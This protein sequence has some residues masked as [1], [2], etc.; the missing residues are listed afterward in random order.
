MKLLWLTLRQATARW[1][2]PVQRGDLALQQF[3]IRFKGRVTV[4]LGG[5]SSGSLTQKFGHSL[6]GSSIGNLRRFGWAPD[7]HWVH[8]RML[9]KRGACLTMLGARAA[10]SLAATMTIRG[11][12]TG[13]VF[14]A[15]TAKFLTPRPSIRRLGRSR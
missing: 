5:H 11:G 7:G 13:N 15:S 3:A 6:A 10:N 1:S 4:R 9:R 14:A 8:I 2:M 12:T